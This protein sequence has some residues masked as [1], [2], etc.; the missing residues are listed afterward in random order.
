MDLYALT[1]TSRYNNEETIAS[2]DLYAT[3]TGLAN[4]QPLGGEGVLLKCI[5]CFYSQLRSIVALC[6]TDPRPY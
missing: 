6:E 3:H 2:T 4:E 5:M 1:S